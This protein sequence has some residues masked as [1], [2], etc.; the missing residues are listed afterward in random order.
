MGC[1]VCG[2][3]LTGWCSE[4][5]TPLFCCWARMGASEGWLALR[6]LLSSMIA[7]KT[8][9]GPVVGAAEVAR[10]GIAMR[11]DDIGT[12]EA[13]RRCMPAALV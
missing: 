9:E 12:A 2:W 8:S 6:A 11:L 13:E 10:M 3:L 1:A 7:C 5:T 4:V